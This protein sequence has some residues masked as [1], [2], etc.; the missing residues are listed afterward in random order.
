MCVRCPA[1]H[2][3]HGRKH[4]KYMAPLYKHMGKLPTAITL[5]LRCESKFRSITFPGAIHSA[6]SCEQFVMNSFP[7]SQTLFNYINNLFFFLQAT[8]Q[9]KI[10]EF[11]QAVISY[12]CHD[13]SPFLIIHVCYNRSGM[14]QSLCYHS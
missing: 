11:Y 8:P 12:Q 14:S 13:M 3:A 1:P 9:P 6:C 7:E 5:I 2:V 4:C 10:K